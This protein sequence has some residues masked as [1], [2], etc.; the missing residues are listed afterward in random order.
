MSNSSFERPSPWDVL[1]TALAMH[2]ANEDDTQPGMICDDW[3]RTLPER[4]RT[5][6][7]SPCRGLTI[8]DDPTVYPL[9]EEPTMSATGRH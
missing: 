4:W 9:E 7:W 5:L 2:A 3:E 1:R 6:P 8:E